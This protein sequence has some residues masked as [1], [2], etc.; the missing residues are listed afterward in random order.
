MKKRLLEK[1]FRVKGDAH[2]LGIEIG[3]ENLAV[4]LAQQL[5]RND[6]FAFPV[7]YPTVPMGSAILRI[8]MTAM[9]T[10]NDV[11]H[12]VEILT[13]ERQRTFDG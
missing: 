10:E 3:N 6:I 11:E 4:M 1:G 2:I 5:Y 7:R 9:H 8:S 12:F 13:Q